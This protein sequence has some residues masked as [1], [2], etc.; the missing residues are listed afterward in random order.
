[1]I[2][3][4]LRI[5]QSWHAKVVWSFFLEYVIISCKCDLFDNLHAIELCGMRL[6]R[7]RTKYIYKVIFLYNNM[8]EMQICWNHIY[9]NFVVHVVR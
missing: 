8:N 4:F 3:N 1:M 6:L 9:V 2:D 5:Y 7:C